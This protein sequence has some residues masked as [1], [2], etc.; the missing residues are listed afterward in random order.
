[1]LR[2]TKIKKGITSSLYIPYSSPIVSYL[3]PKR[4]IANPG[5]NA[6]SN[7]PKFKYPNILQ[8]VAPKTNRTIADNK[9]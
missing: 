5:K 2:I 8:T 7:C 4:A 3:G 1:M 9:I 6:D